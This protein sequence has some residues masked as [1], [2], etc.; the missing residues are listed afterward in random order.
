VVQKAVVKREGK[1]AV[2]E[3]LLTPDYPIIVR[4]K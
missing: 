2:I 1:I 3:G 4:M